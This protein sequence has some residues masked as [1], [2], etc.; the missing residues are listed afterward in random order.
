[1]PGLSKLFRIL[2]GDSKGRTTAKSVKAPS[3]AAAKRKVA[4][5]HRNKYAGE[6][7][8]KQIRVK[9][10]KVTELTD[11]EKELRATDLVG[12]TAIE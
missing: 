12:V 2:V 4:K 9:F 6:D 1:M 7:Q 10:K 11:P 3:K 5:L 8:G